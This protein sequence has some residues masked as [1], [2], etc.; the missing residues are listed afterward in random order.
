MWWSTISEPI[1]PVSLHWTKLIFLC[2]VTISFQ[3]SWW[4]VYI[5]QVCGTLSSHPLPCTLIL[6]DSNMRSCAY[7]Y[8]LS[9]F[10]CSLAL[11]CLENDDSF[12][13]ST[14]SAYVTNL[15]FFSMKSLSFGRCMVFHLGLNRP[16]SLTVFKLSSCGS[17]C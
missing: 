5:I 9:E 7:S 10:I 8:S 12:K 11:F 14:N 15:P 6:S 1:C 17:L 4:G 16:K 13:F 3:L 2:T